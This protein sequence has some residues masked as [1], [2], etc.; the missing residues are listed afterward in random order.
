LSHSELLEQMLPTEICHL[1]KFLEP[2]AIAP[3]PALSH[4]PFFLESVLTLDQDEKLL[5]LGMELNLNFL[6]R[7]DPRLLG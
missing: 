3:Q 2:V 1:P 6:P 5:V 4:G 7:F